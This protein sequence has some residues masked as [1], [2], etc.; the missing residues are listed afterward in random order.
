M[1]KKYVFVDWNDTDSGYGID[2]P[3]YEPQDAAPYGV[4]IVAHV[5]KI[6]TMPIIKG[7]TH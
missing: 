5:P 4:E 2:K 7:D 3:G 1:N 6:D